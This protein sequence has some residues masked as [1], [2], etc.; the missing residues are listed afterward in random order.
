MIDL[1]QVNIQ[2]RK[3][4]PPHTPDPK[5]NSLPA[6]KHEVNPCWLNNFRKTKAPVYQQLIFM[7]WLSEFWLVTTYIF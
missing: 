1:Y 7:M 4:T 6:H 2:A 5:I 3:I